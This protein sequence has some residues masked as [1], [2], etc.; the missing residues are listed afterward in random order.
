LDIPS[1]P[2]SSTSSQQ[3]TDEWTLYLSEE[4]YPYYYNA[5][6]QESQWAE[7]QA[8]SQ[9]SVLLSTASSAQEAQT[10]ASHL[11]T[12]K[13]VACV[14]LVPSVTSVYEWEGKIETSTEVL[15]VIKVSL[16]FPPRPS[17][18]PLLSFLL[19]LA[20]TRK[21]LVA[22][23]TQQIKSLHS[24]S[25]PEVVAM[26][27]TAGNSDYLNWISAETMNRQAKS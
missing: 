1:A 20:Q 5:N 19:P 10:I 18:S 26:D 11:V 16:G 24:Y 21:S 8:P 4:G 15:L 27:I 6:L 7:F 14:N 12:N 25:V 2:S 13:L 9:F 22:E 23:V 17:A 3:P